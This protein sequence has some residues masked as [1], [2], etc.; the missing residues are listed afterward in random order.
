[1]KRAKQETVQAATALHE[2][3]CNKPLRPCA[4]RLPSCGWLSIQTFQRQIAKAHERGWHGAVRRLN[5]DLARAFA[6][7]CRQLQT[8]LPDFQA[9]IRAPKRKTSVSDIYRDLLALEQEFEE[10][11]IDLDEKQ[12]SVTTDAIVLE[13]VYLGPFRIRL[14]WCDVGNSSQPYRVIAVDPHP[15][16]KGEEYTHPH[17]QDELLCE[18]EGRAAIAAALA[19]GRLHDFFTLVSQL[20]HNYGHGSAYAELDQWYGD[21]C[22][23]C[24][25]SVDEDDRY[26]CSRC[27]AMLCDGCSL[28]CHKCDEGF[29]SECLSECRVCGNDFCTSCLES[30]PSCSRNVCDGCQENGLCDRCRKKQQEENENDTTENDLQREA[31]ATAT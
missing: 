20:L 23:A 7:F 1:M 11:S 18:G 5:V 27:D 24:G 4:I 16:K 2:R 6:D 28:A 8:S 14:D 26:F 21:P 31:A 30:C 10:L 25:G 13:D 29:C 12:L 17:V 15:A 19:E 9:V 3:L 22:S